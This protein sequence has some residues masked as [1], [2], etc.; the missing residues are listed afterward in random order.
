MDCLLFIVQCIAIILCAASYPL[1]DG[2]NEWVMNVS[3]PIAGHSLRQWC[4]F[5]VVRDEDRRR[6]HW[7]QRWVAAVP[8]PAVSHSSAPSSAGPPRWA[9]CLPSNRLR[10]RHRTQWRYRLQ[11][12][13]RTGP[14]PRW[15]WRRRSWKI[16]D[17]H[18]DWNDLR[19]QRTGRIAVWLR[20]KY[21]QVLIKKWVNECLNVDKRSVATSHDFIVRQWIITLRQLKP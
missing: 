7:W 9:G 20:G 14:R 17:W 19:Y 3:L 12:L 18:Q 13:R 2:M 10:P 5:L 21:T 4:S 11:S 1:F 6:R 8:W 15:T 16:P